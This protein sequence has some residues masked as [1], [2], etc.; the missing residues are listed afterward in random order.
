MNQNKGIPLMGLQ[1]LYSS[2]QA[3]RAEAP[4]A[5]IV[6]VHGLNGDAKATWT[7][8]K[9]GACWLKDFLPHD[10]EN[11]R[12]M[13]FGYDATAA[14]GDTTADIED[15][16]RDLLISLV[17]EREEDDEAQRPIIF[18]GH[19]LG[20]LVI[21]RALITARN[22][23]KYSSVS[24]STIGILFFGTPHRG[25]EN[26]K[27]PSTLASI[28][29]ALTNRPSPNLLNALQ[30]KS[31]ELQKLCNDFRHQL[32]NYQVCSFYEMKPMKPL[33]KLIVDK[34]SALLNEKNEEQIPV[35]ANHE[36]MCKFGERGDV[37]Y[38][39]VFKRIRAMMKDHETS[40][41]D[42]SLTQSRRTNPAKRSCDE[43][44]PF[45]HSKRARATLSPCRNHSFP[46]Y[47][48][49]EPGISYESNENKGGSI[50][51][52]SDD[53]DDIDGSGGSDASNGSDDGS[54]LDR[55]DVSRGWRD[56]D[57][58]QFDG[59]G[60]SSEDSDEDTLVSDSEDG[61]F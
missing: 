24:E 35:Y 13:T 20:G 23:P 19:S 42:M 37:E 44:N 9:T 57:E 50:S 59:H 12:V 53:T 8:K 3:E 31:K 43:D 39:K 21:K 33:K 5:D 2:N 29:S 58:L 45:P 26:A 22:E 55:S 49:D 38:K 40:H 16:A 41:F 7:H 1:V 52:A 25:S 15:H 54:D 30:A 17:D 4:Q 56:D 11:T 61:N 46:W 51:G 6:A 10:V 47:R 27:I 32:P 14:F 18:I 28:A 48:G 60:D 34:F 36:E